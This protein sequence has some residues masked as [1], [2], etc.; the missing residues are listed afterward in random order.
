[1]FTVAGYES[2]QVEKQNVQAVLGSATLGQHFTDG[3]AVLGISSNYRLISYEI[4]LLDD[5]GNLVTGEDGKALYSTGLQYIMESNIMTQTLTSSV[6]NK[7]LVSLPNGKYTLRLFVD[8]GP[9]TALDKVDVPRTEIPL[10]FEIVG[11][12]QAQLTN[13]DVFYIPSACSAG[14]PVLA[15]VIK[16]ASGAHAVGDAVMVNVESK[17]ADG[18]DANSRARF[19]RVED[20]A[21]KRCAL[22][23]TGIK[24]QYGYHDVITGIEGN[25]LKITDATGHSGSGQ[26]CSYKHDPGCDGSDAYECAGTLTI[27]SDLSILDLRTDALNGKVQP[28][29]ELA[30]VQKLTDAGL[31]VINTYVPDGSSSKGTA[32]VVV[33]IDPT[34]SYTATYNVSKVDP[35]I[36]GTIQLNRTSGAAGDLVTVTATPAESC[37]LE[38]IFVDGT[39]IVGNTFPIRGLHT[40]TAQFT[41]YANLVTVTKVPGGTVEV[42]K[43]GGEDGE[44]VTVT[45]TPYED[46]VLKAIQVNGEDINGNTFTL[47]GNAT[48]EAVFAKLVR[49]GDVMY[50]PGDPVGLEYVEGYLVSS[51]TPDSK[52]F[53]FFEGGFSGD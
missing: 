33:V 37:V 6:L 43:R 53:F 52:I 23:T 30:E 8:S 41:Q 17:Y 9:L 18:T 45:A 26:N 3:G 38:T 15:Y 14:Q 40:V 20:G 5:K 50:F 1:V 24:Y 4:D 44:T 10:E 25:T 51:D 19:W 21:V 7:A 47:N 49:P 22:F 13:G 27:P 2:G 28:V 32:S 16:S 11:R 48:V 29:N 42:D 35:D 39:P 36:G 34:R 46:Y 31:A 12:T